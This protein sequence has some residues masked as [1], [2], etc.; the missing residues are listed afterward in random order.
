LVAPDRLR[1]D[2]SHFTG[3][4]DRAL[5]DIETLVN[6]RI[7]E[8]VPIETQNMPIE[9]ALKS[10]AMAL[11]GEKYGESVR[12][13]SIGTISKELCGGTHCGRTGEIGL[14]LLTHERGV[15]SGTR[16]VE[17]LSGENSL[18]KARSDH[19]ILKRMEELLSVPRHD[20]LAEFD[21]RMDTVRAVQR[22][23]EQRR[24]NV[25]RDELVRKAGSPEIV[26]GIKVLAARVDGLASQDA[27]VLAD[28][29]RQTLGSGIVILG[30]ADGDKASILVAVTD[31]LK[32]RIG[33]GDLVKEL[34]PLIG[35]GGGGRNDLAEAGGK[36]PSRL[37]EALRAGCLAVARRAGTGA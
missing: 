25:V 3:V 30:R 5:A 15:A 33:A 26:G 14:F 36:E 24:V 2:F 17:A 1:F 20:V 19:Q 8:N 32:A 27:R 10:G 4:T 7:L 22:D 16:R 11:F 6:R 37:D 28:S 13:V 35:G 29:L 12:V 34:A 23:L 31:D 9:A 18:A 21:R